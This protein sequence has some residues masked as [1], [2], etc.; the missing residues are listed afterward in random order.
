MGAN[1]QEKAMI[2][3]L[4]ISQWTAR[5]YDK[6][7]ST[8]VA[9]MYA[10]NR[11]AGR[12]HKVLLGMEY[13]KNISKV[14]TKIRTYHYANTL[15]YNNNGDCLLPTANYLDYITNLQTMFDEGKEA[16]RELIGVYPELKEDAK[17]ILNG[18]YNEADYPNIRELERKYRFEVHFSPIPEAGNFRVQMDNADMTQIK[19]DLEEQVNESVKIAMK[20]L[21][22]RLYT[23]V[24]HMKERLGTEEKDGEL[25]N[26]TF[27]DSMI[28]NIREI[29]KLL[30]RL[31]VTDD[32]DL[33]SM[34]KEVEDS[35]AQY[36]PDELRDYDDARTE[37]SKKADEILEKM[38]RFMA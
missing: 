2:V 31:N 37:A 10:T 5:K 8:E 9:D 29:C 17:R 21:W 33:E 11:N 16:V 3:R 22:R 27:R 18:M 19:A 23:C 32:P 13:I 24:G 20:D 15:P 1:V 34:G 6:K 4:N 38:K 14:V 7:V 26:K 35:L 25:V 12:Y 28:E 30:P 36:E